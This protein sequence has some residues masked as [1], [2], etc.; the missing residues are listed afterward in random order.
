MGKG[1]HSSQQ[2]K[3]FKGMNWTNVGNLIREHLS[4]TGRERDT[5]GLKPNHECYLLI[6]KHIC[7]AFNYVLEI[8]L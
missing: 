6:Y 7:W 4:P 8:I 2:E 3:Y 1:D 5:G